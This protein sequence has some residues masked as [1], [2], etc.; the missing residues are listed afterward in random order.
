MR[1]AKSSS[2]GMHRGCWQSVERFGPS[3]HHFILAPVAPSDGLRRIGIGGIVC[4]VIAVEGDDH[5]A[6]LFDEYRIFEAVLQLPFEI[7]GRY[8][9]QDLAP[10]I[11][12]DQFIGGIF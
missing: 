6:A 9:E 8:P 1:A 12:M 5:P 7:V 10:A 2:H 11:R 4:A 3:D